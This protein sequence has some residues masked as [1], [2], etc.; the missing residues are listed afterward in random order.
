MSDTFFKQCKLRS[1]NTFT[2]AWIDERFARIGTSMV[3]K[4]VEE[5][6]KR[7]WEVEAVYGIRRNEVDV[8]DHERDYL[9][10]RKRSDI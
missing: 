10:Q 9:V 5:D 7:R 8:K 6:E 3:F 4:D 2:T 1:G